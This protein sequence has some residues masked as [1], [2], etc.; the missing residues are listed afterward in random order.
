MSVD[1]IIPAIFFLDCGVP[2]FRLDDGE[3]PAPDE[4]CELLVSLSN[5]WVAPA[6]PD[7]G[8]GVTYDPV[9]DQICWRIQHGSPEWKTLSGE[10][11]ASAHNFLTEHCAE[12]LDA[13]A[14]ESAR[15]ILA[16]R[17]A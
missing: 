1:F 17:R 3:I 14:E 8:S 5:E 4:R 9:I 15:E 6:E 16:R 11:F 13:K 12:T 7:N 2:R 10:A